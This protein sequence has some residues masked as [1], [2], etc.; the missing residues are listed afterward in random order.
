MIQVITECKD[1]R[2]AIADIER[3]KKYHI[4]C[5]FP[6][7]TEPEK[8]QLAEFLSRCIAI[9]YRKDVKPKK[10]SY[11]VIINVLEEIERLL[12]GSNNDSNDRVIT[13]RELIDNLIDVFKTND[14]EVQ[15]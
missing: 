13:A 2:Y 8:Y 12:D 3:G 1:Q 6:D 11:P 7:G 10:Q 5:R 15:E 14:K 4:L 9:F